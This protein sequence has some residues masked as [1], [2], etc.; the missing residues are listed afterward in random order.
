MISDSEN[1]DSKGLLRNITV[2]RIAAV[3]LSP[4]PNHL[5]RAIFEMPSKIENT[6]SSFSEISVI[7]A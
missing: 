4:L 2:R 7:K 3:A 1:L 6:F 5:F